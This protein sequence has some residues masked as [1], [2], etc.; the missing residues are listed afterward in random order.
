MPE[1]TNAALLIL[2]AL[3]YFA[4]LAGLFRCR[5]S[6]GS[7]A[8]FCALGVMHFIETYLASNLYVTLPFGII[9][10]P[11]SVVLFSG[12]LM[13]LLLVYIREDAAVVRQPIYG[14][15]IGNLLTLLLAVMLALQVPVAIAPGEIPNLALVDQVG[16]LMVWGTALLFVD[17]I[18][19]ILL[20]EKSRSWFG[21]RIV[22][23][24]FV[25]AA[26]IL[27][28]DQ[29]GFFG[30]L[31]LLYGAD[32]AVMIGGWSMKMAAAALYA[33]LCSLYLSYVERSDRR[34]DKAPRISDV[35]GLLTYRER[36]EALLARTGRDALTGARDRGQLD[37]EG[38]RLVRR[39]IDTG[40]DLTLFVI[41]ID[42]FKALND[43]HGHAAGDEVL[44]VIA[45]RITASV[46]SSDLV[47]RYGGEEF[48]V[49]CLGLNETAAAVLG[50]HLRLTVARANVGH[51][52]TASV[53][54]ASCPAECGDYDA[55]FRLADRRMYMAKASGR[56]RVV[57]RIHE[58]GNAEMPRAPA[59]SAA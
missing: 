10:S 41:D 4:V 54:F 27:S 25:S 12:K 15:L 31:Y 28:F 2:I 1:I 55:L 33:G 6:S 30:A 51:G 8:F 32:H 14:L 34:P 29:L 5:H 19:L 42:D 17:S 23:R 26:A 35:F 49:I 36:Y 39:A 45:E 22:L 18:L 43:A 47:F 9:A 53:G 13:L 37:T 38:P 3:L 7:G 48:V 20:Y 24:M 16:V 21:D 59:P 46:R 57:G 56:N 40:S 11:G 50:E 52:V 58:T 44:K